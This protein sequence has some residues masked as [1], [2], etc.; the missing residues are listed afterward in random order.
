MPRSPR[1]TFHSQMPSC[2]YK[3][4]SKP[5]VW[6]IRAM[7]AG[8]AVSP[9]ITAAGSPGLTWSK[10]NTNSATTSIT[11]MVARIRRRRYAYIPYSFALFQKNG[12][13]EA[14]TPLTFL[15]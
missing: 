15:R 4:L 14:M 11:G 6:R 1:T 9:A 10:V 7:S 3:G 8:D 12:T 13:G 5:R 2:M